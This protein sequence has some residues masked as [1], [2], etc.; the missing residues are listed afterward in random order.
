VCVASQVLFT[1]S[2]SEIFLHRL[3]GCLEWAVCQHWEYLTSFLPV[4]DQTQQKTDEVRA[5][6]TSA[7]VAQAHSTSEARIEFVINDHAVRIH[8]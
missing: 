4:K 7:A 2:F 1:V 5:D 6:A 3:A 8:V